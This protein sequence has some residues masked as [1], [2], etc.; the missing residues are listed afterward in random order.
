M[1]CRVLHVVG[2][3]GAMRFE[4]LL[5]VGI[6]AGVIESDAALPE[7]GRP[8]GNEFCQFVE[9]GDGFGDA[10]GVEVGYGSF[11]EGF[12]VVL[13]EKRGG[14]QDQENRLHRPGTS[15]AAS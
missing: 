15:K 5:A 1:P 14:G 6:S 7:L 3:D 9:A 13:G 8:A 12:R 4:L 11:E 2:V 10:A